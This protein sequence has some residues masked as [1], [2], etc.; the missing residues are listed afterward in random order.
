MYFG[1]IIPFVNDFYHLL[2]STEDV[3]FYVDYGLLS[4]R[5]QSGWIR[6]IS[7]IA[8]VLYG[9]WDPVNLVVMPLYPSFMFYFEGVGGWSCLPVKLLPKQRTLQAIETRSVA[10]HHFYFYMRPVLPLIVLNC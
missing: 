3:L 1:K 8:E 10:I 4:P 7:S 2:D 9:V 5:V 6:E